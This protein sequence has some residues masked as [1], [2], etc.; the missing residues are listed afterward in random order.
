MKYPTPKRTVLPNG[1]RLITVPMPDSPTVTTMVL[2]EAGTRYESHEENGISH[3]LEHMCFKGTTK[4]PEPSALSRELEKIG[5]D[6]NAFTG[7]EMTGYWAKARPKHFN[8]ILD[9]VAD[10]YLDPL[11]PE[12]ELEKER[13]VIIEEINLDEDVPQRHVHRLLDGLMYGNQP[14]GQSTLGPKENI[15]RFT[16]NDFT[17]Y[18]DAH[19]T[20][21]KTAVI[22]AGGI[23][24][25]QMIAATKRAFGSVVKGKRVTRKKTIEKQSA[26]AFV[27][28]EKKTD[29][30]HFVLGFRSY[31]MGDKRY[32]AARL[33][34]GVLGSGMTSRLFL[35]LR[36]EMGVCYYAR[37]YQE[38]ATDTGILKILSGVNTKRIEEVVAA[39][40]G[41]LRKLKETKVSDDELAKVKEMVIGAITMGLET[42]D[43]VADWYH[44]EILR[45]P[46]ETP[47][48]AIKK[49]QKVT[50]ADLQKVARDIFINKKLN[51]AFVGPKR[52][53][54]KLK[55]VAQI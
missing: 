30:T 53:I 50:S 33:L 25:E 14:A 39:I 22:I 11:L 29:Q 7:D 8:D 15:L 46:L 31:P 18:R 54:G 35:K 4:R 43:A 42:S 27:Q 51:L 9:V 45:Q 40:M 2:V 10:M 16:R 28:K 47:A 20:G 5:A 21:T 49:I 17:K 38:S 52:D 24:Q 26:P 37:A 1:I 41:E 36:E 12:K 23:P 19:Y 55:K 48:Q 3:F 13:G 6:H 44:D 34:A 32:V